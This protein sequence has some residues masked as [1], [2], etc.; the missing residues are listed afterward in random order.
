MSERDEMFLKAKE[1]LKTAKTVL[2]ADLMADFALSVKPKWISVEN[3]M[4]DSGECVLLYSPKHGVAEGSRISKHDH[5]EQWR[6]NAIMTNVTHWQPMPE[7]PRKEEG[8]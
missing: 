5:F 4:P 8:E 1:Y 2:Y 7:P 6:W 3:E